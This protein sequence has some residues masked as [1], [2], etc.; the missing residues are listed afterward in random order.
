MIDPIV[1]LPNGV[2]VDC[3]HIVTAAAEGRYLTITGPG[4]VSS[5]KMTPEQIED[6][7]SIIE[8]RMRMLARPPA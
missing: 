8:G 7:I 5:M 3:R 4:F 1:K 6:S 2:V